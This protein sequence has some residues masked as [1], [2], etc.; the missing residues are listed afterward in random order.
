MKN[1]LTLKKKSNFLVGRGNNS[2]KLREVI[3]VE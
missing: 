2:K 1:P 3:E